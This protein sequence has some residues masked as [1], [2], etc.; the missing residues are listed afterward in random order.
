MKLKRTLLATLLFAASSLTHATTFVYDY[1]FDGSSLTTN[2]SASGSALNISDVVNLTLRAQGNDYWSASAGQF[3]WAPISMD[4][5]GIRAGNATWSFL[6]DGVVVDS[7]S[8]V[9]RFSAFGHIVEETNPSI[10]VT[11]DEFRWSFTL[12]D[13]WPLDPDVTTNTLGEIFFSPNPFYPNSGPTYTHVQDNNTQG[14]GT[15]PEPTSLAL[16]GLG[17]AGLGAL[18]RR[19]V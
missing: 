18:R 19:K 12:T 17:L 6:M 5:G 4:E 2:L 15:V 9:G 11:F 7:G 1:T 10:D 13:F 14:P 8:Y 16:L 3:L